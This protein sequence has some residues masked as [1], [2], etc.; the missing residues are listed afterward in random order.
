LYDKINLVV[1]QLCALALPFPN[2]NVFFCTWTSR[3][4]FLN[5]RSSSSALLPSLLLCLL[6]ALSGPPAPL[7][8]RAGV[9]ASSRARLANQRQPA[10]AGAGAGSSGPANARRPSP[11]G[12]EAPLVIGAGARASGGATVALEAGR[13]NL[14]RLEESVRS[15]SSDERWGATAR[16]VFRVHFGS[17]GCSLYCEFQ[18][19]K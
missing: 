17:T 14:T 10:G 13:G 5:V 7:S 2:A 11:R 18:P 19:R 6:A 3:K 8:F 12:A 16:E 1:N 9:H 15:L 4:M